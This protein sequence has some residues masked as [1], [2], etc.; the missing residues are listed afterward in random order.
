MNYQE[1]LKP[2]KKVTIWYSRDRGDYRTRKNLC[3]SF[4]PV[5]VLEATRDHLAYRERKA[6]EEIQR[7]ICEEYKPELK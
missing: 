6:S 1:I 2:Q 5:E 4:E 3:R 7:F